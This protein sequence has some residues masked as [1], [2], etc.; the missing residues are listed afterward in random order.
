MVSAILFLPTN[1]HPVTCVSIK[2]V[3]RARII[4]YHVLQLLYNATHVTNFRSTVS[5]DQPRGYSVSDHSSSD[6]ICYDEIE[7]KDTLKLVPCYKH[8]GLKGDL[9]PVDSEINSADL[10]TATRKVT[11]D[12]F[13]EFD[14]K[15]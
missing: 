5:R 8:Q 12:V 15:C 3:P 14:K 1:R 7:S 4:Y 13:D 9:G 6:S 2:K 10:E 11:N